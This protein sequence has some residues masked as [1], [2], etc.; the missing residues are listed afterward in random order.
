MPVVAILDEL[1]HRV[2]APNPSPMTLDG[3]NTYVIGRT[4]GAALVVD[5]GPSAEEHRQRV[6]A[7][8]RDRDATA[9]AIFVTHHHLDHAEAAAD[10]ARRF[11]CPVVASTRDVAGPDGRVVGDGDELRVDDLM[12]EVIATPGHTRDHVSVRLPTGAVLT[13]DHVLGRGTS[14][15]AYPDGDLT[16]YLDSL[17]RLLRLG[18]DALFPGHGPQLTRDPT[19]VL[20]FYRQHRA[21]R[22]AQVVAALAEGPATPAQLVERIYADVDRNLWHAAQKS[23]RATL[24]ALRS[25]GDIRFNASEQAVWT[26]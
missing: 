17:R 9:T 16:A 22:E 18:P 6:R 24:E 8:L 10:W 12:I 3:T 2:V 25:R 7:V 5:P 13:G 19:A 1:V 11:G 20:D 21:F 26:R 4:G 15:V 23:T 14:V